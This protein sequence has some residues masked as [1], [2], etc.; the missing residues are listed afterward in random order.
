MLIP[1]CIYMSCLQNEAE[2]FIRAPA[3]T[4]INEYACEGSLEFG[5]QPLFI[6]ET[7]VRR[8]ELA[9]SLL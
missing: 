3:K 6:L 4:R 8:C 9:G 2:S 5:M 7:A 1:A